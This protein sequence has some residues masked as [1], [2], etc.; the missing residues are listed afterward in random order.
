MT[1][2]EKLLLK[3]GYQVLAREKKLPLLVRA[4]GQSHLSQITLDLLAQKDKKRYAVLSGAVLDPADTTIR[5]RLVETAYVAHSSDLIYLD[6][7]NHKIHKIKLEL[8]R[9]ESETFFL[10]LIALFI[11]LMI[12]GIIWLLIQLKLV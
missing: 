12:A 11:I 2:E 3:N 5:R 9:P 1:E 6:M 10:Y 7:E 4:D 8:P